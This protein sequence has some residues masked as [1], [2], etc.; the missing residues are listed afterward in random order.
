MC[1]LENL[2]LQKYI[3]WETKAENCKYFKRI[4]HFEIIK[5]ANSESVAAVTLEDAVEYIYM[6]EHKS[7]DE[8]DH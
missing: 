3:N 1:H 4:N 2:M 6:V 8:F 5:F 7:F